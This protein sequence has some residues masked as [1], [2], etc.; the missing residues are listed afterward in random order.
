MGR[1]Y[2]PKKGAYK[3]R[4]QIQEENG[5]FLGNK[6]I[7]WPDQSCMSILKCNGINIALVR[8]GQ[9]IINGLEI[10][11]EGFSLEKVEWHI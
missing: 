7:G 6:E 3:C 2:C 1:R 10:Q 11:K 9:I 5:V 8:G 4:Y